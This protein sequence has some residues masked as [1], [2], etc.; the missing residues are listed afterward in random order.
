MPNPDWQAICAQG[1]ALREAAGTLTGHAAGDDVVRAID[2][3]DVLTAIGGA[4]RDTDDPTD[5]GEA[6]EL[7]EPLAAVVDY[8]GDDIDQRGFV[9]TAELAEAL[10]VEPTAFGRQMG[11]L[12]CEPTRRRAVRP[13]GTARQ[14]RGYLTADL[15]TAIDELEHMPS[16]DRDH[17]G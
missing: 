13:D 3:A 14:V 11:E 8:L 15:R 9:P 4:S 6:V 10:S 17:G 12:G 16:N 2:P 1:R 7:P 5:E